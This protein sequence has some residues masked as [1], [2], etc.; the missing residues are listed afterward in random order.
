MIGLISESLK[1]LLEAEMAPP[2]NV[3]LLSPVET[4]SH[5]T[6]INL[7]LYRVVPNPHLYNRQPLPK[8]GTRDALLPPPLSLNLFYLLTPIAPADIEI[9][10]V[11]AQAIMAEAMRVLYEHPVVP[12]SALESGLTQGQVK[13]TPHPADVEELSKIWTSLDRAL[14]LSMIYEV[15]FADI[16]ATRERAIPKRVEKTEVTAIASDRRPAI[17]DVTPRLGPAGTT[18]LIRGENLRGWRATSRIGGVVALRD[19]PLF[20]DRFEL[21]VPALA[22][23]VYELEISVSGLAQS[24]SLFEVTPS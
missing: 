22:A 8:A 7:F 21:S 2:V 4:S 12:Q 18:V 6:R 3:T 10:Q 13:I 5:Q 24:Q 9:G 1:N 11:N 20:D 14:Q 16:P 15:S 23:G 19:A 17:S